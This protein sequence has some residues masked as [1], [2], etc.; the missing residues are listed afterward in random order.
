MTE[1][2]AGAEAGCDE[3]GQNGL[4]MM[5][6]VGQKNVGRSFESNKKQRI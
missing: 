2:G 1:G 6:S 5:E 4:E 3:S